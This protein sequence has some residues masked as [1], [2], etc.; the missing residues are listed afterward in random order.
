MISWPR[1]LQ[2]LYLYSFIHNPQDGF[3][4]LAT[5]GNEREPWTWAEQSLA[6]M[7]FSPMLG[8]AIYVNCRKY[9]FLQVGLWTNDPL[10][11]LKEFLFYDL[12]VFF[13]FFFEQREVECTTYSE[14]CTMEY[15]PHC[16]SDG[17]VYG[18]RCSFCNAVV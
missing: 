13:F 2:K 1:R 5:L 11:A 18:N 6:V 16:G 8:Q 17:I 4:S 10:K 7:V 12:M 9:I 3:C 15:I 14:I